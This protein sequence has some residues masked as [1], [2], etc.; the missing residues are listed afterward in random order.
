[1]SVSR[2]ILYSEFDRGLSP[3]EVVE[4]LNIPNE[5]RRVSAYYGQWK[6]QDKDVKDQSPKYRDIAVEYKEK[7]INALEDIASVLNDFELFEELRALGYVEQD[8][9]HRIESEFLS[10]PQ[11]AQYLTL[12]KDVRNKRR[13]VKARIDMQCELK[14]KMKGIFKSIADSDFTNT[15]NCINQLIGKV[16]WRLDYETNSIAKSYTESLKKKMTNSQRD[17]VKDYLEQLDQI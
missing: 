14:R 1:M 11:E 13:S 2:E 7:V 4:K 6:K 10:K 17:M 15:Q 8:I 12:L 16:D 3:A 9:L 5:K